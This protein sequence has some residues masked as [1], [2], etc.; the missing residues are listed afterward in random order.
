VLGY[1]FIYLIISLWG[2]RSDKSN[3]F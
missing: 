3:G 1:K 2:T